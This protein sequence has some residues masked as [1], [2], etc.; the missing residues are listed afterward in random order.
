MKSFTVSQGNNPEQNQ[1]DA[2]SS[3]L[4]EN[5]EQD[6][7][8]PADCKTQLEALLRIAYETWPYLNPEEQERERRFMAEDMAAYM[9]QL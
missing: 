7:N 3:E 4:P 1:R 6:R 8:I 9:K 5:R 2:F